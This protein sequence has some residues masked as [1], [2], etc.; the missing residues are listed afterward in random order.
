MSAQPTQYLPWQAAVVE[1]ALA[2]KAG[3]RLPQA[4][5]LEDASQRDIGGFVDYL[6][7]LLL[8]DKPDGLLPCDQCD[9]C[10]MMRAGT[11]S[12]YRFVTLESDEKSKNL[13]KNIK[14]EQIRKLIHELSLSH[15]YARLKIAVIYPA[16][17]MN[18]NSANALLKTLEEPAADVL[19]LLV[20]HSRGR[21]PVTLRS[22]CQLWRIPLPAKA[23]A[24]EWLQQQGLSTDDAALYLDYADG[25]P[26][27]ALDLQQHGYASLVSEFKQRLGHFLR[28]SLG[29]SAL[30][31]QLMAYD[32]QLLRRLVGMTLNA[33]CY[34]SSGVDI[35][36]NAAEGADRHRARQLL[37]L[38]DR[39]QKQLQVE[40]NNLD[41]R[42]QLE[43]VLISLKQILIRRTV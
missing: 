2:L 20:T 43:D 37:E 22:R 10:R 18:R 42:I 21:I 38:R 3:E 13:S 31:A 12:D 14:I 26:R 30:C 34:R 15:Q 4:V 11:Y 1:H 9:A 8:C 5:L 41:L 28:G 17:S 16:E 24:R 6:C 29:V 23:A 36:G 39:A 32:T 25:D 35:A 27:L 19:L 40:E 7:R 33:Y